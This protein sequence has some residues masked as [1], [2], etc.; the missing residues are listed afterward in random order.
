MRKVS[1]EHKYERL[2]KCKL[3][4]IDVIENLKKNL[5]KIRD[6]FKCN[7]QK[8]KLSQVVLWKK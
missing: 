2:E 3:I 4:I 8:P 1:R 6:L 7:V 5:I